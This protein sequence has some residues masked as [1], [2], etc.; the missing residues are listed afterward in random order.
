LSEQNSY[1][2]TLE[3]TGYYE[4]RSHGISA[5]TGSQQLVQII[6]NSIRKQQ[7]QRRDA[8][9]LATICAPCDAFSAK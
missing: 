4:S 6:N 7:F 5:D 1:I 3:L 8:M 2:A 9:L